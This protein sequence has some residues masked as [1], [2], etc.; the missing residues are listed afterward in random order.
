[1]IAVNE[2]VNNAYSAIGMTNITGKPNGNLSKVG[3]Q[4]L[5]TLISNLNAQGYLSLAQKFV[6]A[7]MAREIRFKKLVAGE[8]PTYEIID[9]EPP[10]K[11]AAVSR[12]VGEHYLPL[13][14]IDLQQMYRSNRQ[15]LPT[16]WNYMREYE[17][18][19][20][21]GVETLREVGVL[22]LDGMG[23]QSLRIFINS[24]LPTYTLADTIY[25]PD[26]YNSMLFYGLKYALAKRF[27]LDPEK[28]ADCE[29]EFTAAS[30]LIKRDTITQR[31]IRNQ[32][33]GGSYRD[34][35][36]DAFAP[37]RW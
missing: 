7:P 20:V 36:M 4:E 15:A 21:D 27:N 33:T 12:K 2:L 35:F 13:A 11:V 32:P 29:A 31:M 17:P 26:L 19:I 18:L 34:S 9:M 3:E 10:E 14:S 8:T 6:D 25:L 16:S 1:M 30:T 22:R 5:N 37:T 28:K 24:K 23:S